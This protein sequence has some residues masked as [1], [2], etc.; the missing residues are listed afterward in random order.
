MWPPC[1]GRIVNQQ[2]SSWA[3][4]SFSDSPP[5]PP[6]PPPRTPLLL[7][8]PSHPLPSHPPSPLCSPKVFC[9]PCAHPGHTHTLTLACTFTHVHLSHLL[10]SLPGYVVCGLHPLSPPVPTLSPFYP[11]PRPFWPLP[12]PLPPAYQPCIALCTRAR[13]REAAWNLRKHQGEEIPGESEMG[14]GG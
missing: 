14:G 7:L 9:G 12:L 3:A 5:P 10:P 4:I 1:R 8:L 11:P 2:E 13:L 6:P